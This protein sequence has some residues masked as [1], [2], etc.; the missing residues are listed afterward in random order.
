MDE[1]AIVRRRSRLWPMLM[2]LLVLVILAL[3]AIWIF[4][5]GVIG[6]GL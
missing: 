5:D 6:S 1:I 4:G 3:A 2:T